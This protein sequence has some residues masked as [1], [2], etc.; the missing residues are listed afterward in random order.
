VNK[1]SVLNIVGLFNNYSGTTL[2]GGTYT[3]TGTLELQGAIATNAANITLTGDTGQ[4]LNSLTNS[5]AL[6]GL[7]ANASTGSLSLQSGQVL[8]TTTNLSNAGKITV[9]SGSSLSVGGRYTQTAGATTI[10]GTLSSPSGLILQKGS[11]MG[12]GTLVCAATSGASVTAGDSATK[13]GTLSV[14]G[15]YTQ[16]ATGALNISIGGSTA[17][18]YGQV[19]ASNGVSLDGTLNIKLVHSFIPTIG[20]TFSIV[21]GSAVIG[22][23]ATVKGFGIDS[24]EHFAIEYAGTAVTLTV[25]SGP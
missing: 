1:G 8:T 16:N 25:V 7:V 10:D 23:F 22:Q 6:A 4:I 21:T 5:S 19:A 11:L 13:P 18:T 20:E 15:S 24:S 12:K 3:L 17:G 14:T 2:S 9:G